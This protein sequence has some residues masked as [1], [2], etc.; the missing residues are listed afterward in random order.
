MSDSSD[1]SKPVDLFGFGKDPEAFEDHGSC[2]C[3]ALE[4]GGSGVHPIDCEYY[5]RK[6]P[7]KCPYCQVPCPDDA[8]YTRHLQVCTTAL[9]A[10]APLPGTASLDATKAMHE[11]NQAMKAALRAAGGRVPTDPPRKPFV[12]KTPAAQRAVQSMTQRRSVARRKTFRVTRYDPATRLCE[13]MKP[14]DQSDISSLRGELVLAYKIIALLVDKSDAHGVSLSAEDVRRMKGH[15]PIFMELIMS[16]GKNQ[17]GS[18]RVGL[19]TEMMPL[20]D[21]QNGSL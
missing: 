17:D 2:D 8:Y 15:E 9:L 12:P 19:A 14:W 4:P 10:G 6:K 13:E 18:D 7:G 20:D 1:E 3:G 21:D 16:F 5:S 11:A